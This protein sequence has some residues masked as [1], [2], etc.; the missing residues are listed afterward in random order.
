MAR[1]SNP[2]GTAAMWV[3]DRLDG[4]FTDADFADWYSADGRRGLSPSRADRAAV[5]E[6]LELTGL[7]A[8]R[9]RPVGE[10]CGGRRQRSWWPGRAGG[11]RFL[12]QDEPFTGADV[13]GG[14]E[15]AVRPTG[16]GNSALLMTTHDLAG[17][18]RTCHGVVLMNRTV[19]AEGYPGL[20]DPDQVLGAFGLDRAIGT[21]TAS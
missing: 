1:A 2:R 3:R 13:P 7:T 6:A 14:V 8:L 5:D 11:Q 9:R 20:A 15:R 12:L 16:R 19:V 21:V 18:A 17:A 10:L 4:L